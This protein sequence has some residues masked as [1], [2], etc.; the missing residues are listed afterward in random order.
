[1]N[2]DTGELYRNLQ[3]QEL[4]ELRRKN[5]RIV[6]VSKQVADM[7]EAGKEALTLELPKVERARISWHR[8]QAKEQR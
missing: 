4:E 6:E 7:V 3:R 1:M 8:K 5:P 2:T